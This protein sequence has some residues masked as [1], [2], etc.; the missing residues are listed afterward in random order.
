MYQCILICTQIVMRFVQL[1]IV[2][3]VNFGMMYDKSER[4]MRMHIENKTVALL[5]TNKE[6]KIETN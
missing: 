5:N 2:C 3:V 6:K 1:S 4:H